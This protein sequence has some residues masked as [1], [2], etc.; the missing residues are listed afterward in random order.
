MPLYIVIM[1]VPLIQ[2]A[3][4]PFHAAMHM[5]VYLLKAMH[6]PARYNGVKAMVGFPVHGTWL[7]GTLWH[8]NEQQMCFVAYTYQ[9]FLHH[10][11]ESHACI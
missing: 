1:K 9:S 10:Q 3:C 5:Q 7:I 6:D 8:H 11:M 2:I 4:C